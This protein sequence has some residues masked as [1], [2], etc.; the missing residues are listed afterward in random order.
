[1]D[2]YLFMRYHTIYLGRQYVHFIYHNL[3]NVVFSTLKY[4]MS[5]AN[6]DR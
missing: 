1:M 5:N 6:V 4:V 3:C 2:M